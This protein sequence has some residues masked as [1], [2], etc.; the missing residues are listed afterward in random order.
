MLVD[1][2]KITGVG[3]GYVGLSP[4]V[5]LAQRN[6]VTLLDI[7]AS[8]V[9]KVNSKQLI[10]VDNEVESFLTKKELGLFA[11]LDHQVAYKAISFI[12]VATPK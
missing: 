3:S 9:D 2:V 1:L 6:D 5:L 8:Q 4:A 7:D 11:T 10:V 12:V